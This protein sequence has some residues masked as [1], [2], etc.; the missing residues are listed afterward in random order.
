MCCLLSC[1]KSWN[2]IA[3]RACSGSAARFWA[4]SA[5]G[6]GGT[7]GTDGGG[8]V[9][10]AR[11]GVIWC[12]KCGSYAIK[13]AVGLAGP[14]RGPPTNPSQ[15]QILARLTAGRHPRTNADLGGRI[16]VEVPGLV[17]VGGGGLEEEGTAVRAGLRAV[18][19]RSTVG[20]LRLPGGAR[21]IEV[22]DDLDGFAEGGE[23]YGGS[24]GGALGEIEAEEARNAITSW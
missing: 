15:L 18:S 8:H 6:L 19:G 22:A 20:Y 4:E 10:A 16:V 21:N 5:H 9:R 11:G 17:K 7:G 13:F 12:I 1:F 2:A 14:C 23:E 3:G 24:I